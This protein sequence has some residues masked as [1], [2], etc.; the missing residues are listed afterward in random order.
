MQDQTSGNP[1]PGTFRPPGDAAERLLAPMDSGA[2]KAIFDQAWSQARHAE[3]QRQAFFQL[4]L[5]VTGVALGFVGAS[6]NSVRDAGV[7]V[8]VS[9]FIAATSVL[10]L[11]LNFTQNV[12]YTLWTR[13]AERIQ[14]SQLDSVGAFVNFYGPLR[15]PRVPLKITAL[16]LYPL[17]YAMGGGVST[18]ILAYALSGSLLVGLIAGCIALVGMAV[19]SEAYLEPRRRLY[20]EQFERDLDEVLQ[21]RNSSRYSS[22]G[23]PRSTEQPR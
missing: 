21:R 23:G 20:H 17:A 19:A 15:W 10:G 6:S 11:L 5:V 2:S 4:Y 1:R 16:R 3:Q 9:L 12:A 8:A 7:D 18:G 14:V 22:N 13:Q